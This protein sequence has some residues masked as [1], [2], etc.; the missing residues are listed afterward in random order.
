MG[1]ETSPSLRCKLLTEIN[2]NWPTYLFALIA[3]PRPFSLSF[4]K[5]CS[6]S[7]ANERESEK[8]YGRRRTLNASKCTVPKNK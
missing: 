2:K 1:S 6:R 5:H 8:N 4:F 7:L 3:R